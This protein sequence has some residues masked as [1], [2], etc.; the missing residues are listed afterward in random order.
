[1]VGGSNNGGSGG[2]GSNYG[3]LE[4]DNGGMMIKWLL[5]NCCLFFLF[6]RILASY[7]AT[8]I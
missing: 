3:R 4:A 7:F 6:P 2:L 1:M 8:I 5:D